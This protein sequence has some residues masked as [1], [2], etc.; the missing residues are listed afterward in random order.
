MGLVGGRRSGK[1]M[2]RGY[3]TSCAGTGKKLATGKS[4]I[5]LGTH[6]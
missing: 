6:R 2:K 4:G 3:K 1:W 5:E